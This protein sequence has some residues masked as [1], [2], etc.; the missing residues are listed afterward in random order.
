VEEAASALAPPERWV[1]R[2]GGALTAWGQTPVRPRTPQQAAVIKST[3]VSYDRMDNNVCVRDP[4]PTLAPIL[5]VAERTQSIQ[6]TTVK[7]VRLP[8]SLNQS[9]ILTPPS[10]RTLL[11]KLQ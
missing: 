7:L 1:G 2:H 6:T 10:V 4:N 11:S 9:R 3:A 8:I 5:T